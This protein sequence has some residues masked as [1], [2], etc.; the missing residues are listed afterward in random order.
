[1]STFLQIKTSVYANIARVDEEAEAKIFVEDGI[2]A[3]QVLASLVFRPPELQKTTNI[4]IAE[5]EEST[6]LATLTRCFAIYKIFNIT[7][8]KGV[9]FIPYD[10]WHDILPSSVSTTAY[11]EYATRW[12]NTLYLWPAPTAANTLRFHY[13]TLPA[14]LTADNDK[15]EVLNH[16][17]WI[18]S[19]AS[20]YAFT[21]MEEKESADAWATIG[22]G[23]GVP[24]AIGTQLRTE[25]EEALKHGYIVQRTRATNPAG[26]S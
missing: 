23:H 3:A 11:I 20:S 14:K 18:I 25:F 4:I 22:Q 2:N 1:M 5:G 10:R 12:A 19:M 17:S 16:D 26:T 15:L 6:S 7:S 9:H 24:L 8:N 21:C 13:F